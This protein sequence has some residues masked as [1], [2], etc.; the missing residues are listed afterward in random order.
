[1]YVRGAELRSVSNN[2]ILTKLN[3]PL[4]K[5]I[6]FE[7]C[8]TIEL[9]AK[10]TV[11][12]IKNVAVQ[13]IYDTDDLNVNGAIIPLSKPREAAKT[14]ELIRRIQGGMLST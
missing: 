3:R 4:Q 14:A 13:S 11:D 10:D 7:V 9:V 8:K 5:I 6:Q 12:C 2:G 1:M